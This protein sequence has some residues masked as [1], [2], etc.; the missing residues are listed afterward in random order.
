MTKSVEQGRNEVAE[1]ALREARR[2]GKDVCAILK[3]MQQ[4]AKQGRDARRL[5]KI[6]AA[7]KFLRCRNRK[8]RS[9]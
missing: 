9:R 3:A 6:E 8:K 4:A 7:Q 5:K 2:T 1:E